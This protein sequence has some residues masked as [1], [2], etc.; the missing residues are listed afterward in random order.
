[1]ELRENVGHTEIFVIRYCLGVSKYCLETDYFA[2]FEN[3]GIERRVSDGSPNFYELRSDS[4]YLDVMPQSPFAD[5]QPI[6]KALNKMYPWIG[7]NH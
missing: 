2:S 3:L 5:F 4:E 6:P 7:I 1:M